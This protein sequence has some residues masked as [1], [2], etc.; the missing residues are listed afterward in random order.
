[1]S[2]YTSHYQ[3]AYKLWKDVEG[4]K[5]AQEV[6]LNGGNLDSST[7]VAVSR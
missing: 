1:M 2:P 6:V 5:P 3:T 7:V 4:F